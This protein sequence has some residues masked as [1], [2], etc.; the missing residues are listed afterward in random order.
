MTVRRASGDDWSLVVT[1]DGWRYWFDLTGDLVSM[2]EKDRF[3]ASVIL[4][5]YTG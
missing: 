3:E 5:E 2:S 1:Y 4:T